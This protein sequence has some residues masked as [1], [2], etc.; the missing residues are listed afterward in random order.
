MENTQ[1][2]VVAHYFA[3]PTMGDK[4]NDALRMLA[5]AT[6]NESENITY[7]FFRSTE[8]S[9]RFVIIETYRCAQGLELHRQTEHFQRIGVGIITPL[10]V[11]KEVKSFPIPPDE[12]RR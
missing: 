6:R 8:D 4:V 7:E 1:L 11:R 2:L 10:L 9:D 12:S 3:Q 5:E